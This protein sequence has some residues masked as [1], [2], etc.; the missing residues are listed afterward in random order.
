MRAHQKKGLDLRR[1]AGQGQGSA[2]QGGECQGRAG[3]CGERQG[4]AGAL[5][6][7]LHACMPL[8]LQCSVPPL[9]LK[10]STEE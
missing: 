3:R 5:T 6:K 4:R 8:A 1:K 9:H 2:G 7:L 10:G